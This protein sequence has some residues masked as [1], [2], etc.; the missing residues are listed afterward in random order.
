[1]EEQAERDDREAGPEEGAPDAGDEPRAT[2]DP[3]PFDQ[4]PPVNPEEPQVGNSRARFFMP[5]ESKDEE[6]EA[7]GDADA[8]GEGE[9]D[10]GGSGDHQAA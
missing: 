8:G 1:M 9:E 6:A 2:G 4:N 10:G 3:E 7:E 5:S